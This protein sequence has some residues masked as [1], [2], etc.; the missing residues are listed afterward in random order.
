MQ[1]LE[2]VLEKIRLTLSPCPSPACGRWEQS[3]CGF[4]SPLTP[5]GEGLGERE[6]EI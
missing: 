2:G 6:N 4:I 5:V 3:K 1:Q